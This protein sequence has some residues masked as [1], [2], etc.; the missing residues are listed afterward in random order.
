MARKELVAQSCKNHPVRPATARCRR[1]N[2]PICNKCLIQTPTGVYCSETCATE[3]EAFM[4]K[5]A[6]LNEPLR[7]PASY[8]FVRMIV[9]LIV[10]GAAAWFLWFLYQKGT[11]TGLQ[12][13]LMS[14]LRTVRGG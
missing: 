3:M 2:M 6:D 5:A 9:K 8:R 12:H 7:R 14:M 1:C 4:E 13:W 10:F 11:F